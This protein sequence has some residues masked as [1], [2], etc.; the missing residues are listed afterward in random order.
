M[1]ILDI[2]TV[3]ICQ[4]EENGMKKKKKRENGEQNPSNCC[5]CLIQNMCETFTAPFLFL[6]ELPF[7]FSVGPWVWGFFG[8]KRYN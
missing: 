3:E 1:Q 7:R 8:L 2:N 4:K 5:I 6:R